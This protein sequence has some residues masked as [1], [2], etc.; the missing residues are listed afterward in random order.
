[1]RRRWPWPR[2]G[3]RRGIQAVSPWAPARQSSR[4]LAT[5]RCRRRSTVSGLPRVGSASATPRCEH[6]RAT[7]TPLGNLACNCGH[8]LISCALL[9]QVNLPGLWFCKRTHHVPANPH[10]ST[11]PNCR[12]LSPP[13]ERAGVRGRARVGSA[14]PAEG[15]DG[16]KLNRYPIFTHL[17]TVAWECYA[18]SIETYSQ[19]SGGD[20]GKRTYYLCRNCRCR[21]MV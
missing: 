1:M 15:K 14:T 9:T 13:G 11:L 7:A 3:R 16:L 8:P 10:E 4:G 21:G 5:N 2:R 18:V 17:C 12:G 20:Y 6:R 19:L